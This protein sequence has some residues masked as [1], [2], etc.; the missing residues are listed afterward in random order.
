M[1]RH[2]DIDRVLQAWMADGP[3][4]IPDRVVDVVATRI[5]VQRQRRAWPFQRRTTV[6]TQLKLIVGLAAALVVAVVGY[7]LL[8]QISGPGRPSAAP[9]TSAQPTATATTAAAVDLPDAL[10]EAGRYRMDLSFIDPGFAITADAPAGWQGHPEIP[11]ITSPDGENAGILISFMETGGLFSDPCQ[12]D[13]AG[14]GDAAQAGD[15]VVGPSAAD[16]AAA[17]KAN[18]SYT[19]TSPKPVTVGGFDGQEIELQLP[20]FEV[21]RACDSR[22][23]EVVGDYFVFP[24]GFYAQSSNSRWHLYILDVGGTRLIVMLSIAAGTPPADIAAAEAIVASFE[25]TP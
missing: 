16:L 5:G 23:G 12:W 14:T 8:P 9:T 10:L 13:L 15:I 17:L 21:I 24:G 25:I 6:S 1:N 11:A 18:T 19:S 7:N 22:E 2:S 4:A 3:T 20:S